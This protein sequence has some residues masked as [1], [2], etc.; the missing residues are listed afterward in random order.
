MGALAFG[1]TV[2][3]EM[4]LR[5]RWGFL[6]GK[7]ETLETTAEQFG[8]TRERIRQQEVS[9]L[10]K[11]MDRLYGAVNTKDKNLWLETFG[12]PLLNLG[13]PTGVHN[14]LWRV[15]IRTIGDLLA[16]KMGRLGFDE[17][18]LAKRCIGPKSLSQIK[19]ALRRKGYFLDNHKG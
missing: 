4:I 16:L 1:L 7:R 15:D 3:E 8:L 17:E 9:A 10:K 2:R 18:V 5:Y 13:L 14:A 12:Q 19:E 6:T 11:I